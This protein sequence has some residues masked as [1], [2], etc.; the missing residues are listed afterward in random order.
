[1]EVASQ[2]D[3]EISRKLAASVNYVLD[4][5]ELKDVHEFVSN[6]ERILEEIEQLYHDGRVLQVP[7]FLIGGHFGFQ[8]THNLLGSTTDTVLG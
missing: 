7:L 5:G 3:N 6:W 4:L 8:S 2:Y 1:M